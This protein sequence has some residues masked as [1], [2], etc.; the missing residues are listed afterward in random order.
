[1]GPGVWRKTDEVFKE[2]NIQKIIKHGADN[3]MI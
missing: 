3:I 2:V 1:M